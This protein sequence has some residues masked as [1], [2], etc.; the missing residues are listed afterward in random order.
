MLRFGG[1]RVLTKHLPDDTLKSQLTVEDAK[2]EVTPQ[3]IN[4]TLVIG[5]PHIMRKPK[6]KVK[7]RMVK[8]KVTAKQSRLEKATSRLYDLE[9]NRGPEK[10]LNI[11]FGLYQMEKY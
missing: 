5:A 1:E 10:T 9:I 8:A 2:I 3:I 7:V 11:D 6:D 4:N